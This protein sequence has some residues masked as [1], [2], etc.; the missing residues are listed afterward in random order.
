MKKKEKGT[1]IWV[2][3][4]VAKQG[5]GDRPLQF[6]HVDGASEGQEAWTQ[7]LGG[8]GLS[9]FA[10]KEMK[11]P[12]QMG[13]EVDFSSHL[14]S[15]AAPGSRSPFICAPQSS[16]T[17]PSPLWILSCTPNAT[18]SRRVTQHSR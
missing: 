14:S 18:T 15:A 8:A 4:Q 5:K 2:D 6:G 17:P 3:L 13:L 1:V 12:T 9:S 7:R 11:P 10:S 16:D